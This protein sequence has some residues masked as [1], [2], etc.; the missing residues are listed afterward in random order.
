MKLYVEGGGDSNMLKT[1]CRAGFSDFLSKAGLKG[2]MPRIVA[3]GSRQNAYDSF[4]TAIN[5]GEDALLL[6]DSEASVSA[7]CQQG[8][9]EN[10]KPW[11]HL[12]N[13]QGDQWDKP[14]NVDDAD[15]HLMVQCMEAWFLADRDTLQSFFGQGFNANALPAAGNRIESVAKEQIYQALSATTKN[16]KT[17][18]KYGKGEHSFKLLALISPDRVTA[19]SP[20]AKR[21]IDITGD[22]MG[23]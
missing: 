8:D 16:C 5:T 14:E 22:K 9:A 23:G 3:C 19:A 1:A 10:W 17:K 13:R 21:F 6:V 18:A 12:K 7:D 2:K 11:H 20:W 4:C 15:C